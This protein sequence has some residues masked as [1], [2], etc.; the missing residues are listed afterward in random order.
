MYMYYTVFVHILDVW[1]RTYEFS[2]ELCR[3]GGAPA[4]DRGLPTSWSHVPSVECRWGRAN[5]NMGRRAQL[6][7]QK[8]P[9]A[10]LS[11]TSRSTVTCTCRP[12]AL[13]SIT[14][15]N[16]WMKRRHFYR[17]SFRRI[18]LHV[19]I[20]RVHFPSISIKKIS[21]KHYVYCRD[22]RIKSYIRIP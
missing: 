7:D 3:T 12:L 13:F 8:C 14:S 10:L 17:I 4:P 20:I 15:L 16:R 11:D 5:W 19:Q 18:R 2:V 21:I 1:T 22:G 6:R 9:K